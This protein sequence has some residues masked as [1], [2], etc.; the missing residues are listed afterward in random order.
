MKILSTNTPDL[1][2]EDNAVGQMLKGVW[3][4]SDG[5]IDESRGVRHR[6]VGA[7]RVRRELILA[8]TRR[9]DDKAPLLERLER[10]RRHGVRL[11]H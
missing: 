5:Q 10:R 3:D 2:F 9:T 8:G 11:P 4:A 1:F 6:V 7:L